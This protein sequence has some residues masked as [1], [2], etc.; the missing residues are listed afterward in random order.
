[1]KSYLV[2]PVILLCGLFYSCQK[3]TL[4][5]TD[6]PNPAPVVTNDQCELQITIPEGCSATISGVGGVDTSYYTCPQGMKLKTLGTPINVSAGSGVYSVSGKYVFITLTSETGGMVSVKSL[7]I[8][9]TITRNLTSSDANFV[10]A[11]N[12]NSCIAAD[13][14]VCLP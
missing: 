9:H 6:E 11:V 8:G 10:V 12:S 1:M 14:T 5:V 7:S 4:F 2:I 3:E 13:F